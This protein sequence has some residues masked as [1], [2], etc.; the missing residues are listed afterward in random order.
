MT[1]AIVGA[2]M[3]GLACGEALAEAGFNVRLYDKGRGPGGRMSTRRIAIGP[4]KLRFDHG[5]QY[6]SA[7]S[8]GFRAC[9][10]AWQADGIVA[11]WPA[12]GEGAFVGTPAMNAPVK[13]MA[14][15]LGAAFGKRVERFEKGDKGW[16]LE[17]DGLPQ[18]PFDGVI[19]AVPAE[20]AGPLLAP[21]V[22][23]FAA[24]A[25]ATIAEPCWTLMAAFDGP[26]AAPDTLRSTG[27]IA[28]AARNSAKPG[29]SNGRSAAEP[30]CWVIQASP[31]WTRANLELDKETAAQLLLSLFADCVPDPLPE[32]LYSSAHR[33]RYARSGNAGQ[34]CL[35]DAPQRIGVCGDWLAGPKVEDAWLSGTAL[36]RMIIE[37]GRLGPIP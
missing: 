28:W 25:D 8:E 31:E 11:P 1:I 17:G 20:Q 30:D 7:K 34:T 22:P 23:D 13:S 24:L 10:N 35:W 4:V 32:I 3:A 36:A 27:T 29:R 14:S 6:F 37:E 33:W 19:I 12:A 15:I 5:A 2:G 18:H 16:V 26:V 21:Y 9:V